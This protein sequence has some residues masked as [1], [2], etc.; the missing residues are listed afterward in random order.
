[1]PNNQPSGS[2]ARLAQEAEENEDDEFMNDIHLLN[3]SSI[4]KKYIIRI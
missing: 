2:A 1:V 3:V 4:N